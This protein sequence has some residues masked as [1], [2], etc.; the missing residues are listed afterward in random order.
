DGVEP[1]VE[2]KPVIFEGVRIWATAGQLV[3]VAHAEQVGG[4]AA[5]EMGDCRD[6]VAPYEGGGG[7]AVQEDDRIAAA[8]FDVGQAKAVHLH[9]VLLGCVHRVFSLPGTCCPI[10]AMGW[11]RTRLTAAAQAALGWLISALAALAAS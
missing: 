9:E 10:R 1:A 2:I 3:A 7:V 4:Q 11:E 5:A 8:C 6:D